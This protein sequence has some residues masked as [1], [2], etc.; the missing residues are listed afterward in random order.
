LIYHSLY[1]PCRFLKNSHVLLSF[2]PHLLSDQKLVEGYLLGAARRSNI[3]SHIFIWH[4][5]VK[6]NLDCIFI[7][8]ITHSCVS[9][10][11]DMDIW[12]CVYI[13][14]WISSLTCLF[15]CELEIIGWMWGSRQQKG[16]MGSKGTTHLTKFSISSFPCTFGFPRVLFHYR[17]NCWFCSN[18]ALFWKFLLTVAL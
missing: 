12:F 17:K 16:C 8:I 9:S 10:N 7:F 4:I 13:L 2:V 14:R 11:E 1:N 15:F 18:T 5:Q 3:F 6:I